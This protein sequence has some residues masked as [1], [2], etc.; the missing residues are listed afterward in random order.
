MANL[1][2]YTSTKAVEGLHP[3]DL[4]VSGFEQ[5]G[6]RTN[7]LAS[8]Y[9][10]TGAALGR[11]AEGAINVYEQHQAQQED[12]GLASDHAA[13]YSALSSSLDHALATADPNDPDAAKKWMDGTLGPTLDKFGADVTSKGGQ[14]KA[15]QLKAA[16][17][18]EFTQRAVGAQSTLAGVAVE[19]AGNTALNLFS[20]EARE[21]PESMEATIG[22]MHLSIETLISSHQ[23]LSPETI[24]R[25]RETL[26]EKSDKTIAT[27]A[28]QGWAEK[29]PAGLQAAIDAG[30]FNAYLTGPEIKGLTGFGRELSSVQD[31]LLRKKNKDGADADLNQIQSEITVDANGHATVSPK[32]YGDMATWQSKWGGQP[33]AAEVVAEKFRAGVDFGR[34][35]VKDPTG[36]VDAATYEDLRTRTDP[37]SPRRVTEPELQRAFAAGRLSMPDYRELSAVIKPGADPA[38]VQNRMDLNKFLTDMAPAI[39][40][41]TNPMISMAGGLLARQFYNFS[42]EARNRFDDGIRRGVSADD[43]LRNVKSPEYLG[44]IVPRFIISPDKLLASPG[45]IMHMNENSG[46]LTQPTS[47]G[48]A[49]PAAPA[50][51]VPG[52]P[53][54][55]PGESVEDF[56]K[57]LHGVK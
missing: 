43:M 12:A 26:T 28:G 57:R 31:A 5:L 4:G 48:G 29:D 20:N 8:S 25:L 7:L 21:H 11:V 33:G 9:A 14:L 13:A 18:M 41:G 36:H 49:A 6:R 34:A 32:Y 54:I 56:A 37:N 23:N 19:N 42:V 46:L 35:I 17:R 52:A 45:G 53:Q 50:A 15:A 16:L 3:T 38:M 47:P 55:K 39:K 27:S 40:Q 24:A 30:K 1:P 2:E 51:A 22:A 10:E 44:R